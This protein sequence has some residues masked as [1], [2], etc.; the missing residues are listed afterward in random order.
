MYNVERK[1]REAREEEIVQYLK[2]IYCKV[3]DGI[4]QAK[5]ERERNEE[6]LV[7]LVENVVEKMKADLIENE[8]FND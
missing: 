6:Q 3:H 2:A 8:D 5:A 1:E 7:R 4:A